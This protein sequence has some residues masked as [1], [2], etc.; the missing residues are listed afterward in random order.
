MA[1]EGK[2][3][4]NG[5]G[6]A[7][8]LI[9]FFVVLA[10][11]GMWGTQW[12]S[13]RMSHVYENDARIAASVVSVSSRV[14]GWVTKITVIEGDRI[15]LGDILVQVDARDSRL[16]LREMETRIDEI[17]AEQSRVGTEIDMTRQQNR[18]RHEAQEFRVS[19]SRA[20]LQAALTQLELAGSEYARVKSLVARKVLSR[21][22]WDQARADLREAQEKQREAAA[23]LA[24]A[25]SVLLEVQAAR[26]QSTVLRKR[27]DQLLSEQKRLAIQVRRQTLD[28]EDRTIR[29]STAGVIDIT[30]VNEGEYVR[31]G[32][33]LMLIHDP[34][35]IWIKANIRETELRHVK[36]GAAVKISVDAFPDRK[37]Q[38]EVFRIG[39]ATTSEFS[40]LPSP[41]PSGNFT[42]IT[43]R[44]PV[45]IK[46]T[47]DGGL[48]RPGMMVE[49][50][51][52]IPER[53]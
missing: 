14:A 13:Y 8:K 45:R 41:N 23:D 32:Q 17:K 7:V 9:V 20:K 27:L 46:V 4:A 11:G 42:K 49:V 53:Q 1:K 43:Q 51:I 35:R 52:V 37:F 26:G 5:V 25:K 2:K 48:L 24:V 31:P 29:S 22:R 28:L 36:I 40:L 16:K 12:L 50:H 6:R 33:R 21:Q 44:L 15:G 39:N 30:F 19:A 38:G 3:P 34:S 18:R 47:Q 10:A